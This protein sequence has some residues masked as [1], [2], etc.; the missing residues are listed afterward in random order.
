M[1]GGKLFWFSIGTRR[2]LARICLKSTPRGK[3]VQI[4][5]FRWDFS[6][7]VKGIIWLL[8]QA[9][10]ICLDIPEGTQECP[11]LNGCDSSLRFFFLDPLLFFWFSFS[12]ITFFSVTAKHYVFLSYWHQLEWTLTTVVTNLTQFDEVENNKMNFVVYV[13]KRWTSSLYQSFVVF[14]CSKLQIIS[15]I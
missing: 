5:V 6:G 4:P 2:F 12:V 13:I 7:W 10:R 8:F 1:E 9:C 14:L 3:M 15:P 11:L